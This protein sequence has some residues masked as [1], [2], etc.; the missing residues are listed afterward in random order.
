MRNDRPCHLAQP[1]MVRLC[2]LFHQMEEFRSAQESKWQDNAS[3]LAPQVDSR[4][5]GSCPENRSRHYCV[6][7]QL[8]PLA[9]AFLHFLG[10][11]LRLAPLR[12]TLN[13]GAQHWAQHPPCESFSNGVYSCVTGP[14]LHFCLDLLRGQYG[15]TGIMGKVRMN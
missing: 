9:S 2:P 3:L 6:Y 11:G 8:L 5:F 1:N 15:K 13:P 7:L 4:P 12:F 14:A 10:K